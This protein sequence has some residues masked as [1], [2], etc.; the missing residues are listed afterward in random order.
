MTRAAALAFRTVAT[1]TRRFELPSLNERVDDTNDVSSAIDPELLGNPRPPAPIPM[2][3]VSVDEVLSK[4]GTGQEELRELVLRGE[5]PLPADRRHVGASR[6]IALR[7]L[8]RAQ[9]LGV[10][11][12]V[13]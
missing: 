3:T 8:E 5:I 1:V 10:A 4:R 13:P 7:M 6:Q 2:L 9:K 12:L 11:K